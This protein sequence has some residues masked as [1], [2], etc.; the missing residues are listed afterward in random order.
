MGASIILIMLIIIVLLLQRNRKGTVNFIGKKLLLG[1]LVTIV[2][3][4][5]ILYFIF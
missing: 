1:L 2:L 5:G 3:I 4:Q